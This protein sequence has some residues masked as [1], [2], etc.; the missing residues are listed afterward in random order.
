M[1]KTYNKAT[2]PTSINERLSKEEVMTC[3]ISV[4]RAVLET[5]T[6][7]KDQLRSRVLDLMGYSLPM[8]IL[9][10]KVPELR[11]ACKARGRSTYGNKKELIHRLIG[12]TKEERDI[13]D[14]L[15]NDDMEIDEIKNSCDKLR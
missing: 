10:W 13:E 2:Q 8:E 7:T 15:T 12:L 6:G 11:E 9:K 5:T 14:R 4:L 1:S 3:Q